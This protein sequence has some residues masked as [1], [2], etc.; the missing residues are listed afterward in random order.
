MRWIRTLRTFALR[1]AGLFS[2]RV[3]S[4]FEAEL[5]S[6]LDLHTDENMRSGMTPEQARRD[7]RI[8]LGGVAQAQ[9]SYRDQRGLPSIDAAWQD[10]RRSVR[11]LL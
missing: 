11:L 8:K 7:A 2:R 5:E 3:D 9:E 10:L 6:H 4:D 1:I